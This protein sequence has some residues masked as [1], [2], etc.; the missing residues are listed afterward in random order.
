MFIVCEGTFNNVRYLHFSCSLN[1]VV[2][3]LV[4]AMCYNIN[5]INNVLHCLLQKHGSKTRI[6]CW[7]L[8]VPL[9][10][11]YIRKQTSRQIASKTKGCRRL[12]RMMERKK[13]TG[14]RKSRQGFGR[15]RVTSKRM[16]CIFISKMLFSPTWF[17]ERFKNLEFINRPIN[18]P[19]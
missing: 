3:K 19:Y 17:R 18:N 1:K 9:L 6:E 7:N 11:H 2:T 4:S 16:K 10:L 14:E 12:I 15:P 8:C 5:I 13:E